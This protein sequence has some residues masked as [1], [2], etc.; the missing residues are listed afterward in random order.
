MGVKI[1]KKGRH[2]YVFIDHRGQRKAKKVGTREAA[3]K[4]KREVEARL[5]LGD[6]GILVEQD[7]P[8]FT[9]YSK[10]WLRLHVKPH[11]KLSTSISYKQVLDRYLIPHFGES[12][13]D[14]ITR[15]KLKAYFSETVAEEKFGHGTLKNMLATIRAIL[16]H[17]VEDGLV[18][19]NPALRLGKVAFRKATKRAADFFTRSEAL[20]FLQKTRLLRP[21]RYALFLTA[22]R[23][24]LRLGELLALE[25]RDIQFGES[26]DDSNRFIIVRHNFTHGQFTT[27]KSRKE[28]RVDLSKELRRELL[29]LRDKRIL[30]AV[31]RGDFDESRQP[32]LSKL[33]FPSETGG[34]INGSN[35][36]NRDFLP[37]LEAAGIRRVT[38]HSLRHTFASLLIQQGASLAYVKE[39]MGHSSIQV[40]VDIYG[41]LIP[42][43]NIGWVDALDTETTPHQSA[44]QTQPPTPPPSSVLPQ[45]IEMIGGPTR[46]RTWDQRIMS[47][48]L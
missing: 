13:L 11:C 28:R 1:R 41:H 38:F 21:D 19:T 36:F 43:G 34:P 23:A 27:T 10:R 8:T 18:I 33:V 5:A 7:C 39:Q 4:V 6:F 46:T 31:S 14:Q 20:R 30:E 37:I 12:R 3:E 42:G 32:R 15:D 17:A 2:W 29:E 47:P 22:L 35:V 26:Q 24:G 16:S 48:L 40:T 45:V 44:T 25:W 9:D